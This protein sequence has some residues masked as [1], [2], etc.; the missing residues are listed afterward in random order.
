[1][2]RGAD[3]PVT[4]QELPRRARQLETVLQGFASPVRRMSAPCSPASRRGSWSAGAPD[5]QGS[6]PATARQGLHAAAYRTGNGKLL[7]VRVAATTLL[8]VVRPA[9]GIVASSA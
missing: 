1:V 7:P 5:P 9:A 8:D 2:L 3:A 4:P 6:D